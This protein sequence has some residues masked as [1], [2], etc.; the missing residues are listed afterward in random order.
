MA[1][2]KKTT[3]T[4]KPAERKSID[5]MTIARTISQKLHVKI[6]EVLAIIE[7]EQKLTMEAVRS[8]ARVIKKNYLTIEGKKCEGK[9]NWKSPLDGKVY[10]L[11]P[12]TRVYVR[13]GDGF[14]RYIDGNKKMPSKMCRFVSETDVPPAD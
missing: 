5:Q 10:N 12:T 14:K 7:E 2:T 11:A 9:K 8:G 1:T 3:K 6:S 13:I 4:T